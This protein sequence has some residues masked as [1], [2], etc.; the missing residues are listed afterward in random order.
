MKIFGKSWDKQLLDQTAHFLAGVGLAVLFSSTI[1]AI[2]AVVYVLLFATVREFLQ[3]RS[4]S[5]GWGSL[6][7]I[8]FFVLGAFA[9]TLLVA[10]NIF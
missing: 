10:Y 9:W 1:P 7:D 5:I 8:Y 2:Y 3:H 6:F 4:W